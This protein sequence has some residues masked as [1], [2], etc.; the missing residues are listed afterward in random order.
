MEVPPPPS[1]HYLTA[2]EKVQFIY[3]NGQ[4]LLLY[5]YIYI[6]SPQGW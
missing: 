2:Y 6:S 3:T 4:I 1:H 5:R